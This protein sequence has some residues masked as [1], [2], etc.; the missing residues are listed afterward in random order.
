MKDKIA[1][2]GE[3]NPLAITFLFE[4]QKRQV[5]DAPQVDEVL[6]K[7]EDTP[8]MRGENLGFFY[9]VICDRDLVRA[10][11]VLTNA[12]ITL[13]VLTGAVQLRDNSAVGV[14]DDAIV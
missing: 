10:H 13:E 8:A 4:L 5:L 12:G 11:T 9:N 14:I 1:F 3:G 6:T 7:I 2:Y